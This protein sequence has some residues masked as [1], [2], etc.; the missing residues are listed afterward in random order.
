MTTDDSSITIV[1]PASGFGTRN[2]KAPV[3]ELM[4]Y[5][6]RPLIEY[7]FSHLIDFSKLINK[8]VIVTRP[9]KLAQLNAWVDHWL[10]VHQLKIPIV[11]QNHE[12]KPSEEW[13]RTCLQA[14]PFWSEKNLCL[15]PDTHLMLQGN[16][17][18][19]PAVIS[20]LTS[21]KSLWILN[22]MDRAKISTFGNVRTE[23]SRAIELVEKPRQPISS[24]VWG[25]FGFLESVGQSLLTD[26]ERS[27]HDHEVINLPEPSGFLLCEKFEDLS[28]ID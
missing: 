19:I 7:S 13:P 5:H 11:F 23:G 3:K 24:L 16:R 8:I 12:P 26:M 17:S 6:G 14:K 1:I 10:S 2:P 20:G 15:L 9:A 21:F 22:K 28:R 4:D 27:T 25:S 18:L